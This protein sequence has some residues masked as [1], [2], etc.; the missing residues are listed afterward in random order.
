VR[1]LVVLQGLRLVAAGVVVG[2]GAALI[3]NR[4]LSTLLFGVSPTDPQTIAAVP[5]ALVAVALAACL[6]PAHRAA[7]LD[8]ADVLRES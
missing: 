4:L 6:V 3:A 5:A 8:P 7:A 2:A 1:R